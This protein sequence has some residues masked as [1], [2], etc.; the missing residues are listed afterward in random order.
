MFRGNFVLHSG[1]PDIFR[2]TLSL[3]KMTLAVVL[4]SHSVSLSKHGTRLLVGVEA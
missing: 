1:H 2:K 3:T 4:K